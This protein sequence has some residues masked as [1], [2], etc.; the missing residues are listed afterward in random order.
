MNY[1]SYTY[2]LNYRKNN[3]F[4]FQKTRK[5][6]LKFCIKVNIRYKKTDHKK[7]IASLLL[8]FWGYTKSLI[9][10]QFGRKI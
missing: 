2:I 1:R 9:K 6:G 7:I 3:D 5:I 8:A 10:K 4:Y